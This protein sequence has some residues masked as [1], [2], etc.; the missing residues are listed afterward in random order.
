MR[1][2]ALAREDANLSSAIS[3]ELL[4]FGPASRRTSGAGPEDL[5]MSR[6]E[7]PEN[8]PRTDDH[9]LPAAPPQL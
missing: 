3:G 2:R 7:H 6:D 5:S 8:N 1:V 9:L 4:E